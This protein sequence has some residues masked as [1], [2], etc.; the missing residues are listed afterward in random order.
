MIVGS[1]SRLLSRQAPRGFLSRFRSSASSVVSRIKPMHHVIRGY[2]GAIVTR[3][4]VNERILKTLR[5]FDKVQIPSKFL[6]G[7]QGLVFSR[8]FANFSDAI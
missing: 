3:Q 7:D 8:I 1:L 6:V 4:E 5:F 2:S